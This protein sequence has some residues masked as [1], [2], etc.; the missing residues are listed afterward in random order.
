MSKKIDLIIVVLTMYKT[1]DGFSSFVFI[2]IGSS[3][4]IVQC[5]FFSIKNMLAMITRGNGIRF[6]LFEFVKYHI[7]S[8]PFLDTYYN[9]N[10]LYHKSSAYIN[11][12]TI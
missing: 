2:S 8:A 5:Q 9:M 10:R 7:L 12:K 11:K 1:H 4:N 3:I 6:I